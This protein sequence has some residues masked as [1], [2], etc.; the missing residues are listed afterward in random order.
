MPFTLGLE[1]IK[2]ESTRWREDQG[3]GH[4]AGRIVLSVKCMKPAKDMGK[5]GTKW[6]G[7]E[8]SEGRRGIKGR[9]KSKSI[10]TKGK[11]I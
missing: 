9:G 3:G 6:H 7:R 4:A 8:R 1:A 11:T 10:R 5:G 2:T